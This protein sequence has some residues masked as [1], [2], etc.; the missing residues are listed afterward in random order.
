MFKVIL[1]VLGAGAAAV[2]LALCK[3]AG[4]ADKLPQPKIKNK[5]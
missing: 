1:L 3:A 4:R 5:D 2:T